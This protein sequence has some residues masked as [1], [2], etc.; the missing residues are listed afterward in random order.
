IVKKYVTFV[1]NYVR[2]IMNTLQVTS[3]EFREKQKSFFDL[4]DAGKEIII[5]RKNK[6]YL[7]TSIEE[8][9]FKL[10]PEALKRIELA[11]QQYRK[12]EVTVCDTVE[13]AIAHLNSL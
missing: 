8:D 4:A 9:D 6:A 2:K 10:S 5:R 13:A 1:H 7:L 11:R 3:R 12:G